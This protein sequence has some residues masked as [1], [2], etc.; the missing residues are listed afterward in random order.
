MLCLYVEQAD[1]WW[2]SEPH[3]AHACRHLVHIIKS[4]TKVGTSASIH[5][6][7]V[8]VI[9]VAVL[10]SRSYEEVFA[11]LHVQVVGRGYTVC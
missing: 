6:P 11:R 2:P 7:K 9:A 4:A 8:A 10:S 5:P 3:F 1:T